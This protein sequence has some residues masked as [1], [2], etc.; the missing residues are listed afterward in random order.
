MPNDGVK[1]PIEFKKVGREYV[2]TGEELA[3]I[4]MLRS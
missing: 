1:V 3:R 4:Q 2:F